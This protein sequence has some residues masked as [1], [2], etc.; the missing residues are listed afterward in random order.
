MQDKIIILGLGFV[1]QANA[2]AL[3]RMGFEIWAK[4][5]REVENLYATKDFDKIHIFTDSK[6]LPF[7]AADK[8]PAMVCVNAHNTASGQD[9]N[10]AQRALAEARKVTQGLVILRTTIVPKHLKSLDFDL[11]LPEFLHE[12]MALYEV[13]FP[14]I[15]VLGYKDK[16]SADMELPKFILN[17][18]EYVQHNPSRKFFEGSAEEAAYIKYLIN[19]WNSMRIGFVNEF[20]RAIIKEGFT[21]DHEKIIDFVMDGAYYLRYGKSFGGHCLRKDTEGFYAEHGDMK[22]LKGLID[23]N[24]DHEKFTE[25]HDAKELY[26]GD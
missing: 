13:Q 1:G 5:I 21:R 2:I 17:W 19:I 26:Y 14:E 7:T 20:G 3:A 25:D 10:P 9:L 18:K 4:D 8:V 22:I 24:M 11:Y 6:E 16:T 23:S 15:L 12:R